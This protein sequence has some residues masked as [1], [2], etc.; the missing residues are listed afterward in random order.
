MDKWMAT[1][2]QKE[3]RR[4]KSGGGAIDILLHI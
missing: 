4:R 3:K 1:K 2:T